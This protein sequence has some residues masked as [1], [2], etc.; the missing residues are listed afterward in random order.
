VVA[1]APSP[2]DVIASKLAR[3]DDKDKMFIESYHA[4]RPLKVKFVEEPIA[5]SSFEPEIAKRAIAY[6]HRLTQ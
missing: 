3:L 4:A 6:M 1:V 5:A 2:E